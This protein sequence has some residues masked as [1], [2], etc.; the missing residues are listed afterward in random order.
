MLFSIKQPRVHR[1]I[2]SPLFSLETLNFRDK[3]FITFL[4]KFFNFIC[5]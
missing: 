4:A 5:R 3:N 1:L 2:A